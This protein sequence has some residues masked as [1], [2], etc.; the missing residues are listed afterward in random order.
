M[1]FFHFSESTAT[2]DNFA[3]PPDR[4]M[5]KPDLSLVRPSIPL[6]VPLE[7]CRSVMANKSR[8]DK[9][10]QN[11]STERHGTF[12]PWSFVER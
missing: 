11:T 7:M 10:L 1:K 8:Y 6:F 12:D 5:R 4:K 2:K 3:R 9:Y